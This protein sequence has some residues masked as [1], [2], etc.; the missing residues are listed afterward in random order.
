MAK[1][2]KINRIICEYNKITTK[3]MLLMFVLYFFSLHW[4]I[5]ASSF[6]LPMHLK[7]VGNVHVILTETYIYMHS[8]A[9]KQAN[10][11]VI[12]WYGHIYNG[13]TQFV[14]M[15]TYTNLGLKLK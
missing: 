15:Q 12:Q 14:F 6:V 1:D 4:C 5:D 2:S 13:L 8:G 3:H 11:Y 10:N 9:R 7:G